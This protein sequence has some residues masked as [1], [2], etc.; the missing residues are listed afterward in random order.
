MHLESRRILVVE[1]KRYVRKREIDHLGII[2]KGQDTQ[3]APKQSLLA[4]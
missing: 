2:G 4:Q 3:F 1:T